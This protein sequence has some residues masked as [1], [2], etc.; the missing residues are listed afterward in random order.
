MN[1]SRRDSSAS[2][3]SAIVGVGDQ[4][5]LVEHHDDRAP[6]GVDA[7]GESL[8]LTGDALGGVDHEEGDVGVV[9]RPQGTHE[10]VVL[11][12]VVDPRA[13]AHPGG[14]DEDDRAVLGVDERVDR[15]AGRAW[16][17][18]DDRAI[19]TD[20]AVEQRRL[21][22]VGP[23]DDGD[24]W[25]VEPFRRRLEI[26][27]HRH[28]VGRGVIA[29]GDVAV[30]REAVDDDV[31]EIAGTAAVEGAHRIRL[32]QPEGHE[33]PA[34]VLPA[35]VV[36]LVG[37][38]DHVVAAAPQPVGDRLVVVGDADRG[39]DDEQHDV[40]VADR[41]LDLSGHLGVERRSARCPASSR[42]CR[43]C[44]TARRATPPRGS[45]DRGSPRGGPRRSPPA[46]R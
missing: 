2:R 5:P 26:D 39:V 34:L 40:G 38:E 41:R 10:R 9:D 31:E 46:R 25:G 14:V 8:V 28:A 20:E 3:T 6:A 29:V 16:Q 11:G 27:R 44:G 36:G 35:I 13:T 43:R 12:G 1:A 19:V 22:D 23:A 42:R 32:A 21:A 30:R 24:A 45:C 17:V 37:D 4:L 15:V 18:V 33:L 7:F